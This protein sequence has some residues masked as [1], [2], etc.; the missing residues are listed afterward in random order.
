[1]LSGIIFGSLRPPNPDKSRAVRI[2]RLARQALIAEAELTPKPG[3]V[4]RRGAGAHADLSLAIVKRSAMA[5]EPHLCRMAMVSLTAI[6]GQQLREQ[7]ALVGRAAERAMLNATNGSNAHKGAIWILGLL[8]SAAAMQWESEVRPLSIAAAAQLIASFADRAQPHLI[9]HGEMVAK[10]YGV[11]GSRGEALSGFPHV[12]EVGL[13]MLRRQR[14]HGR[15]EHVARLDALLGI[16]SCLDDTCLLYRGGECALSVTKAGATAVINAGGCGTIIGSQALQD[17]D[18]SL[19]A[20]H[21]SPGGS[22]DLLA[23]TL[24]LDALER[25]LAEVDADHSWLEEMDGTD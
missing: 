22:A 11:M 2:A 7:L 12:L 21:L 23:A 1:M 20:L 25:G 5:I 14:A 9:S 13:P 3:L 17:L 4:D 24:F 18:R 15:T 16:M 6:P 19:L 8:V 10:K